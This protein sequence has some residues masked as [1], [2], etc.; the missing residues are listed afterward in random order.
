MKFRSQYLTDARG[1]VGGTTA[2]KN[3]YGSFMRAR[4]KPVNPQSIA[5][6]ETRAILKTLAKNWR[7]LTDVQR[8]G[9]RQLATQISFTDSI[10]QSFTLTGEALYIQNNCNLAKVGSTFISDAPSIDLNNV[11]YPNGFVCDIVATPG[12]EDIT[13]NFI[14]AISVGQKLVIESSGEVSAGIEYMKNY[15]KIGVLDSAFMTG[16]SIKDLY[17]SV[18]GAVPA[19]GKVAFFRGHIVDTSTGFVSSKIAERSISTI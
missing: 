18:F 12:S 17:E 8:Q 2:S 5:Q 9:W 11:K 13:C 1:S 10:G 19:A 14:D 15:R 7:N 16:S 4:I 3:H 6:I